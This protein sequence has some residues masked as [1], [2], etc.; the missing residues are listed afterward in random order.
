ME[1]LVSVIMPV[2]KTEE[3]Q[4]KEAVN[5][6]LRQTYNNLQLIIIIDEN[7]ESTTKYILEG[8]KDKRIIIIENG[9]NMG[10]PYSLNRGIDMSEGKYIFRMDSDDISL[11]NRLKKQV[12][13]FESHPDIDVLGTYAETF[14]DSKSVFKSSLVDK[15]IKAELLW[16]N[17]L[18]HPTVAFRALTLKK[19]NIRYT[20]G[21]SE[22]YRMWID[23]AFDYKCRFAVLPDVLLRY[24][25]HTNQITNINKDILITKDKEIVVKISQI[26]KI[27]LSDVEKNILCKCRQGKH[28]SL[29]EICHCMKVIELFKKH[30]PQEVSRNAMC[31]YYKK[32]LIKCILNNSLN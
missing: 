3:D 20:P 4:L 24:R 13:Y 11:P 17:P 26:L 32:G 9:Q 8:I 15:K 29:Y 30:I 27:N 25:I 6:I 7:F 18:V 1:S 19:K 2:Y 23:M 14:G 16:K 31:F 22:D 5:S 28:M 12:E 21:A 10:L